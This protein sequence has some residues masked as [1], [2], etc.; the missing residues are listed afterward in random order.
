MSGPV[1][2][3]VPENPVVAAVTEP[4][5]RALAFYMD[6]VYGFFVERVESN[7]IDTLIY[8]RSESNV[9]FTHLNLFAVKRSGETLVMFFDQRAPGDEIPINFPRYP[10]LTVTRGPSFESVWFRIDDER[11]RKVLGI[12]IEKFTSFVSDQPG[13][14]FDPYFM[15]KPTQLVSEG[16][17]RFC[18]DFFEYMQA[19]DR[20]HLHSTQITQ[21]GDL[22]TF[23]DSARGLFGYLKMYFSTFDKHDGIVKIIVKTASG[24]SHPVV[25]GTAGYGDSEYDRSLTAEYKLAD[26]EKSTVCLIFVKDKNVAWVLCL[27]TTLVLLKC[28]IPLGITLQVRLWT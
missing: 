18:E 7:G 6:I 11:E 19:V 22:N 4:E 26:S 17:I 25:F 23:F 3:R 20:V 8:M 9:R 21:T 5:L 10:G 24:D 13:E 27:C 14:H 12:M 1:Q 15:K 16:N 2:L 28:L